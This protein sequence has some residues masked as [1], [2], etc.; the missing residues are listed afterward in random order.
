MN[1][2]C[3]YKDT[4]AILGIGTLIFIIAMLGYL[5]LCGI[6]IFFVGLT[7]SFGNRVRDLNEKLIEIDRINKEINDESRRK[8]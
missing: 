3:T 7:I 6:S 8:D 5:F 1:D 2:T 4:V